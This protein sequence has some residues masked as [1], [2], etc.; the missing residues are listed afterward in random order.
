MPIR[1]LSREQTWLFP[2]TLDELVPDDHPARFVAAFV[3]NIDRTMSDCV[4]TSVAAD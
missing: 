1:P 4:K 2:P 3:D